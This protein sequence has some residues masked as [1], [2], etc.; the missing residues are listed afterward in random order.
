MASNHCYTPTDLRRRGWTDDLIAE[1]LDPVDHRV[2]SRYHGAC[3]LY[4]PARVEANLGTEKSICGFIWAALIFSAKLSRH[5]STVG[6]GPAD[7][8]SA[9]SQPV[10]QAGGRSAGNT[11]S[12]TRGPT[13]SCGRG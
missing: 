9:F 6:A 7:G 1:H 2:P 3:D 4:E 11:M 10:P 12:A 13:R 5:G 8:G